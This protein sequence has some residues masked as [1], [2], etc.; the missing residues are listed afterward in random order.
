MS[1]QAIQLHACSSVYAYTIQQIY[2]T[3]HSTCTYTYMYIYI[4]TN[5]KF[6]MCIYI[7]VYMYVPILVHFDLSSAYVLC[8]IHL[9]PPVGEVEVPSK[10]VQLG[11]VR[12]RRPADAGRAA[13]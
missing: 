6:I 11:A 2:V 3:S 8:Y 4:C 13:G 10:V 5:Y 7:Y 9:L 1:T 12:H